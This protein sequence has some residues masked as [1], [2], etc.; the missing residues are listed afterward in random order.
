MKK[1]IFSLT[2]IFLIFLT[3]IIK[4]STKNIDNKIFY[5]K[6]DI[7]LLYE[8][9][10][11]ALLDFNFLSSPNKL[12]NY[13]ESFFENELHPSDIRNFRKIYFNKNQITIEEIT[14]LENN[15]EKK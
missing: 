10:E 13:Q 8:Q 4:N 1:F 3:S 2:I 15:D 9:Y 5:L 14:E 12:L 6:E 7:R 11:L